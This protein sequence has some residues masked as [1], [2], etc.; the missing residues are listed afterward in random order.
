RDEAEDG[1]QEAWLQIMDDYNFD[2]A[3][4]YLE[5]Y[6]A[7]YE[8]YQSE[9]NPLDAGIACADQWQEQNG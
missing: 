4:A 3:D 5:E 7:A 6:V 8:S 9:D 2:D 1:A